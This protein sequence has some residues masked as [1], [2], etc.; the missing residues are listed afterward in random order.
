MQAAFCTAPGRI[1]L[2][3]VEAPRLRPGEV[4]VKV[5]R[6]GICGSDLHFFHGGFPPPPVCPGHE[7]SGEVVEVAGTADG[8]RAGDRVAIEPL[9]V[10][11]ECWACRSGDYQLCRKL[12]IA[13][14]MVD[15]GFAE[16]VR[17]PSYALFALPPAVDFEVGALAEPLAVA[18]HGV[19]LANLRTGDRALVLGVGTIGLLSVAAALA[20][21]A[22]E[23]WVTA[24]HAHQRAA[25]EALGATRVFS[26]TNAAAEL[27]A[28]ANDHA[29]D[30]VIETI[31]GEA[32]TL[33]D[34]IHL[35]RRGGAI[36]VLGVFTSMPACNALSLVIKEVRL[37]GA[38]TYGR[39][40]PRTDF[41]VALQ[42]LAAQPERFRRLLTHSFPLTEIARAFETAADKRSGS[43][44][45][46]VES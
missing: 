26:G 4:L 23:V 11:R 15:G 32:D 7:I 13:G 20:A 16:Y 21:G 45:V 2:R 46:S 9:V 36:A 33:N 29:I 22:G 3:D 30:V 41:D 8:V 18:V 19:R 42:L 43:I 44:K 17:M 28:A 10:C 14:T 38:L 34:A 24:R 40:G 25:A 12:R 6:C 39:C 1:E 37:V 31:G 5:R 27:S 35:V